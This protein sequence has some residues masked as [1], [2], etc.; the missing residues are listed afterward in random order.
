[1]RDAE[2]VWTGLRAPKGESRSLPPP[3]LTVPSPAGDPDREDHEETRAP[4]PTGARRLDRGVLWPRWAFRGRSRRPRPTGSTRPSGSPPH[5]STGNLRSPPPR[6][7]PGPSG[8]RALTGREV[9]HDTSPSEFLPIATSGLPLARTRSVSAPRSLRSPP[10]PRP[11]GGPQPAR[12]PW[13][14]NACRRP[15]GTPRPRRAAHRDNGAC[16]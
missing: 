14:G 2:R 11:R 13:R 16:P 9:R 7:P 8:S 3:A 1:M 12:A 6:R 15:R 4:R 10:A 5:T